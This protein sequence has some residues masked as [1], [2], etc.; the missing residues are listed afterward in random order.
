MRVTCAVE[1]GVPHRP[2]GFYALAAVVEKV[3]NLP[4]NHHPFRGDGHFS[5]LQ[6]VWLATDNG[7]VRRGLGER[8]VGRAITTFAQIGSLIA[9]PHLI[10]V[11]DPNDHDR[12]TRFYTK[13]GFSTYK[14]GEAMFLPLKS[15]VQA[16]NEIEAELAAEAVA[17]PNPEEPDEDFTPEATE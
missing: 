6:L 12:L 1:E 16:V 5:A 11:P 2:I 8:M 10:V 3:S 4:A 15:A 14:D 13:L 9:L 17:L 7:F